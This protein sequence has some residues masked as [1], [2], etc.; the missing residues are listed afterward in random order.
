M[1][2]TTENDGDLPDV[3]AATLDEV[4]RS[5]SFG[6]FAIL[7]VSE[8]QF[9]Q[10]GEDWSPDDQSQAFLRENESDPW[11][12]EY[13]ESE[14]QF[15]AVGHVTLTLVRDT[16]QAYLSGDPGWKSTFAWAELKL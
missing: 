4:L 1:T 10:A 8:A 7:A 5:G 16:F 13:R 15:R 14:R 3:D 11:L 2:F 6:K 12:L 9:I